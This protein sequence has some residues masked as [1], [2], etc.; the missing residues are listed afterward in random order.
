MKKCCCKSLIRCTYFL[1]DQLTAHTSNFDKLNDLKLACSGEDLKYFMGKAGNNVTY[2][3]RTA[4]VE[5]VEVFRTG[6]EEHLL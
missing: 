1:A 4:V 2:T 6:V 5:L 3:S